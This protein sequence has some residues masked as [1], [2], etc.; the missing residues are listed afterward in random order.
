MHSSILFLSSC[1]SESITLKTAV[2]LPCTMNSV[3]FAQETT[4]SQSG[5]LSNSSSVFHHIVCTA[6]VYYITRSIP[7]LLQSLF[8]SE[9]KRKLFLNYFLLTSIIGCLSDFAVS[10]SSWFVTRFQ[11]MSFD[12][13]VGTEFMRSPTFSAVIR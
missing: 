1:P 10:S 4:P 6:T 8:S 9:K 7:R 5:M 11:F 13:V 12:L 3:L 2:P